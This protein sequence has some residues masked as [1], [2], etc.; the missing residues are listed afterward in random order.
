MITDYYRGDRFPAGDLPL[1]NSAQKTIDEIHKDGL[2]E[3]MLEVMSGANYRRPIVDAKLANVAYLL[4]VV[5]SPI[6]RDIVWSWLEAGEEVITR[7]RQSSGAA[8]A[9][10]IITT[11][12]WI[13]FPE[14]YGPFGS[15]DASRPPVAYQPILLANHTTANGRATQLRVGVQFKGSPVM[16]DT[17]PSNCWENSSVRGARGG[18][19]VIPDPDEQAEQDRKQRLSR[20]TGGLF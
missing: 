15:P 20:N 7:F 12:S 9:D 14:E 6:G 16:F 13:A 2:A 3:P 1:I 11:S 4:Q 10:K 19:I 8:G 18:E 17:Y 5:M